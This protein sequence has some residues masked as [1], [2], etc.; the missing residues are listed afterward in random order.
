MSLEK[1]IELYKKQATPIAKVSMIGP[2]SHVEHVYDLE[3]FQNWFAKNDRN[4]VLRKSRIGAVNT[5]NEKNNE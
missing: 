2:I 4:S 5:F 1:S 3:D